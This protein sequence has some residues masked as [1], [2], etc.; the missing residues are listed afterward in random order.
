MRHTAAADSITT[1][2][3]PLLGCLPRTR[4][5]LRKRATKTQVFNVNSV[6]LAA[7]C[8]AAL[9]ASKLIYIADGSHLEDTVTG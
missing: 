2:P 6:D 7:K 9:G 1:A 5:A 4:G 3:A 8:A